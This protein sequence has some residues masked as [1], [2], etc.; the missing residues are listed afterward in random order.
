MDDRAHGVDLMTRRARPGTPGT[1]RGEASSVV[2]T[3]E[4]RWFVPGPLPADIAGWFRG[5]T[6]VSEE[7]YD[8][9]LLGG[10]RDTGVKR[11]FRQTLELKVR[12]SLEERVELGDGLTGPL[13]VWR[14]WSPADG[15][16]DV[17]GGPWV[18]VHKSVV[19]RRFSI[20][21]TEIVFSSDLPAARPGCDVE[22]AGSPSAP[23]GRGRSRS[24]RS[25][26]PQRDAT[27]C[28]LRGVR[29]WLPRSRSPSARAT[30][31]R[32]ATPSGSR[33]RSRRVRQDLGAVTIP[34]R[35]AADG[36]VARVTVPASVSRWR[37][38]RRCLVAPSGREMATQA[39]C[40]DRASCQPHGPEQV[41][42][43]ITT[44][45][46]EPTDTSS[47]VLSSQGSTRT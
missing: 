32:W 3:T 2:D 17:I 23:S 30:A 26:R 16:D 5:S 14:K 13:E 24:P 47:T 33:S 45:R 38:R 37:R 31:V 43:S 46:V 27:R 18:D 29:W 1:R 25:A 40:R 9:Y 44:R 28:S 36:D 39:G 22:L 11:R 8:T 35:G 10:R 21:G 34:Q 12:Q 15:P 6:G 20:D 41:T 4:L 42:S 7:R 19:K